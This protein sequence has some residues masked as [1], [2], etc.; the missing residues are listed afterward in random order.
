MRADAGDG[1]DGAGE[2]V[3]EF[4][5]LA[6]AVEAEFVAEIKLVGELAADGEDLFGGVEFARLR[7][8]AG[9][10]GEAEVVHEADFVVELARKER[11]GGGGEGSV[12]AV[13][14]AAGAVEHQPGEFVF[15]AHRFVGHQGDA[16][17]AE[18]ADDFHARVH[19][20]E[21][22]HGSDV[23]VGVG[24]RADEGNR[25]FG[26][27]EILAVGFVFAFDD[28]DGAD[29][30]D[31]L[32]GLGGEGEL[33]AEGY[34]HAFA[35]EIDAVVQVQQQVHA[36]GHGGGGLFGRLAEDDDVVIQ[37]GHAGFLHAEAAFV[38]FQTA[39]E[40]DA[41]FFGVNEAGAA[42]DGEA[43][44][45]FVEDFVFVEEGV[46]VH[47]GYAAAP[48][49][50]AGEGDAAAAAPEGEAL[51]LP[52][53]SGKA[54]AQA[55]VVEDDAVFAVDVV[56]FVA[57]EAAA[58]LGFADAAADF[59]FGGERA[60]GTLADGEQVFQGGQLGDVEFQTA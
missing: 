44:A 22:A 14:A 35:F 55:A 10:A 31:V 36:D 23:E 45:G 6:C 3:D 15:F 60:F 51:Y 27:V 50:G 38:H 21:V 53:L 56:E 34:V 42:A 54:R 17:V 32:L 37:R 19:R 20:R 30:L 39:F 49:G 8:A 52:L 18:A 2:L 16:R 47:N 7:V 25:A 29:A 4:D 46:D 24:E 1:L 41:A 13:A 26:D 11:A 12:V 9:A 58:E 57:V 59:G 48:A 43:A 28:F 5:G 40:A 33:A